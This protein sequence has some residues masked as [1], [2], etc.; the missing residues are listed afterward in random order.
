IANGATLTVI[1]SQINGN[2]AG[3]VGGLTG[4]GIGNAGT[5]LLVESTVSGN[6]AQGTGGGI[7]SFTA[8]T[9]IDSTVSGNSTAANGGGI[10]IAGPLVARNSTISGN[11]A[12]TDGGGISI[13]GTSATA[14]LN[15][16]TIAD[17]TA[18]G[19]GGGVNVAVGS[20]SLAN[21]ILAANT[22][23]GG[24]APDC[25][26]TLNSQGYNLIESTTGC[27]VMGDTTGNIAGEGAS[28]GPLGLN[29]GATQTHALL[30]GSPAIDAGNPGSGGIACE[31]VDQ[32]GVNRPQD[33]DG[34]GD[35]RCDIGAFEVG[36]FPS[37][38]GKVT[39]GGSIGGASGG[40]AGFGFSV[41]VS[42][43][44]APAGALMYVDEGADIEISNASFHQLTINGTQAEFSGTAL[45]NGAS[46]PFR[47]TVTDMGEPGTADTFSLEVVEPGG[48][49]NSGTL[50]GGNIKIHR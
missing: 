28:L 4:G 14:T 12:G 39:G 29:G 7:G 22:D 50:T 25:A 35:A 17:N 47:V 31:P 23:T 44:G 41:K 5:V 36:V 24:E 42:N 32:R 19:D 18:G 38:V 49:A 2:T 27:S 8:V 46:K 3:E 1:A 13:I 40:D 9:L 37:T 30:P 45:V 6:S 43:G 34:N 20:L 26:G 16:V 21:T 10:G 48:Y 15:N 33:G 11:S